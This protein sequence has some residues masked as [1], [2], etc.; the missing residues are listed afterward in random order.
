VQT[1]IHVGVAEQPLAA[2]Y[3]RHV[4]LEV[5]FEDAEQLFAIQCGRQVLLQAGFG[6]SASHHVVEQHRVAVGVPQRPH[7]IQFAAQVLLTESL[8]LDVCL[9]S[10][11]LLLEGDVGRMQ[12]FSRAVGENSE[13]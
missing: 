6:A 3:G 4:R 9:G 1:E 12:A 10:V 2:K 7:A 13:E 11:E 5:H 8:R